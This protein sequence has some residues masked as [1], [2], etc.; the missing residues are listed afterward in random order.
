MAL[1]LS[2]SDAGFADAFDMLVN[3]RREA[4]ADVSADVAAI[5]KDVRASGDEAVAR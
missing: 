5:I 2:T 1:R 4:D 3:A